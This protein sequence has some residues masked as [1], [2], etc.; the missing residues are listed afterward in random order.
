MAEVLAIK[1]AVADGPVLVSRDKGVLR[2]TLASPPANALSLATM[3]ALQAE[4]DRVK[5]DKS[6]RVIIL[7]ASG[8]VFC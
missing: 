6:V 7:A 4:F 5:D 8:K 2:L 1:P 3:A